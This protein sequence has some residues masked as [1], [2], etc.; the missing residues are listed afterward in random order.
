MITSAQCRAGPRAKVIQSIVVRADPQLQIFGRKFLAANSRLQVLAVEA[1]ASALMRAPCST[2]AAAA[3][4][5]EP[6][7][8]PEHRSREQSHERRVAPGA[9][10]IP[11]LVGG[12]RR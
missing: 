4:A 7:P 3:L 6:S 10:A 8:S 5:S 11:V 2:L 1:W 12:G 9:R